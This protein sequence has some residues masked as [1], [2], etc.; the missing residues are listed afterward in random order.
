MISKIKYFY[1]FLSLLPLIAPISTPFIYFMSGVIMMGL[2][3]IA[4]NYGY[5][6]CKKSILERQQEYKNINA[7]LVAASLVSPLLAIYAVQFYSGSLPQDVIL[8]IISGNSNYAAYQEY[9]ASEN[10]KEFTISK[11]PAIVCMLIIKI[12]LVTCSIR[13]TTKQKKKVSDYFSVALPI[14]SHLYISIGRGTSIELFE[15]LFLIYFLQQNKNINKEFFIRKK[16]I[17]FLAISLLTLVAFNYN[18]NARSEMGCVVRGICYQTNILSLPLGDFD[19][20]IYGLIGYFSFGIYYIHY[21]ITNYIFSD[22]IL[23]LASLL[24]FT[25]PEFIGDP[26]LRRVICE[27]LDCGAAWQPDIVTFIFNYGLIMT[28][29]GIY[30]CGKFIA[31]LDYEK[32]QPNGLWSSASQFMLFLTIIS[33]PFGNVVT[34]SSSNILSLLIFLSLRYFTKTRLSLNG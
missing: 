6:K 14:L 7:I 31:R 20:L 22:G 11:I 24:P 15:L 16:S 18:I 2:I 29:Y 9:F 4:L 13:Y 27:T 5:I 10:I 17:Y 23:A 32:A 19:K 25:L 1:L 28:F 34:N 33:L 21:S 3:Y 26:N 8:N 12:L 30:M